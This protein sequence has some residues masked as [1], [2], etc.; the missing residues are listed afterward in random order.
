MFS[1]SVKQNKMYSGQ[2]IQKKLIQNI[3]YMARCK[4]PPSS[5]LRLD[6]LLTGRW[7]AIIMTYAHKSLLDVHV[8]VQAKNLNLT[9]ISVISGR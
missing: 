1:T 4:W 5:S 8:P 6:F 7:Y 3:R 2:L 9:N